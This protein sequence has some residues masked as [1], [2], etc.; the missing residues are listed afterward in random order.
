MVCTICLESKRWHQ[1]IRYLKCGHRFHTHC[2]REW[3]KVQ[4]NKS[5]FNSYKCPICQEEYN[6]RQK[7]NYTYTIQAPCD[8][9]RQCCIDMHNVG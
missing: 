3:E 7:W 1:S 8:S 5:Q 9:Y 2:I 6:W 4:L